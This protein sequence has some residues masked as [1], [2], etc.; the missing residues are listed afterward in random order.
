MNVY[1]IGMC[2]SM[3]VYILIGVFV[4]HGV[5]DANDYYV[6]GRRAPVLTELLH[7]LFFLQVCNRQDTSLVACS[8]VVIL[9]EV[10]L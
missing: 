10:A 3:V 2:I 7:L 9:D 1:L 8:L 5:K 4:S 6:A